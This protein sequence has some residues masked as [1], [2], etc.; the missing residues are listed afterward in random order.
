MKTP[1]H[2]SNKVITIEG[3]ILSLIYKKALNKEQV[4]L[5]LFKILT[6]NGMITFS[7][8]YTEFMNS[9][10]NIQL[11]AES[12]HYFDKYIQR[13]F[14]LKSEIIIQI[15]GKK[16][17]NVEMRKAKTASQEIKTASQETKRINQDFIFASNGNIPIEI[18]SNSEI[19]SNYQDFFDAAVDRWSEIIIGGYPKFGPDYQSYDGIVIEVF[20]SYIDGPGEI[21]GGSSPVNIRAGWKLPNAGWM[22]FDSDDIEYM[23]DQ[24]ILVNVIMHEIGHLLGIGTFWNKLDLTQ[25]IGTDNPVFVGQ[26]AMY[27]F[28]H[29]MGYSTPTPVPL[30]NRGQRG[31]R[32]CHWR[33]SVFGDELMTGILRSKRNP[34]SHLTI[35]ALCDIGYQVNFDAAD[36]FILPK[37]DYQNMQEISQQDIIFPH[38]SIN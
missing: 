3:E 19:I 26:R 16:L 13:I 9:D 6:D 8:C 31:T 4:C 7:E 22:V 33:E 36:S 12:L 37:N 30:E 35:A 38:C 27:E 15:K 10:S 14:R 1:K 18:H 23:Y 5:S 29:M 24:G 17:V 34:I 28:A 20:S 21:L 25:G 11:E 2:Q 32:D